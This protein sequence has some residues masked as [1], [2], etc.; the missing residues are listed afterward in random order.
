MLRS[1]QL[2]ELAKRVEQGTPINGPALLN[3]M[4]LTQAANDAEYAERIDQ[5]W[6]QRAAYLRGQ[7]AQLHGVNP[8][9]EAAEPP[10]SS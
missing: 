9:G 5:R 6:Q 2:Q 1:K 8:G 4:A 3:A 7:L 10:S